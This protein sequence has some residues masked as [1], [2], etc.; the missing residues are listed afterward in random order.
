MKKSF[1]SPPFVQ[2]N[3]NTKHKLVCG[4]TLIELLVVIAIIGILA[5]VVLAS[6]NSARDRGSNAAVKADLHGIRNQAELVYDITKSYD[7]VCGNQ[8]VITAINHALLVGGDAGT[9]ATRCNDSATAWAAN[10]MLK[11]PEDSNSYWCVDSAG[12][13]KAEPNELNGALSC[14]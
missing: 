14:Q 5:S 12:V 1:K 4:F 2:C 10:V 9:V 6:L 3:K 7:T 8:N 11:T 13:G